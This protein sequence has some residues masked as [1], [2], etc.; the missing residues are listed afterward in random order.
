MMATWNIH[1]KNSCEHPR[2]AVINMRQPT[3]QAGKLKLKETPTC[4]FHRTC[5]LLQVCFN[6]MVVACC[7]KMVNCWTFWCI[8][9]GDGLVYRKTLKL[10]KIT[11]KSKKTT[12]TSLL[13]P[14]FVRMCPIHPLRG[15]RRSSSDKWR[16][17]GRKPHP[18]PVMMGSVF[19]K[20]DETKFPRN[21]QEPLCVLFGLV[22][23][24]MKLQTATSKRPEK[25]KHVTWSWTKSG[26]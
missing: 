6:N 13:P 16:Q 1:G 14:P 15:F 9:W 11:Q 24:F 25:E 10:A 12:S 8:L 21:K 3:P 22:V 4:V 20:P 2:D 26:F 23:A 7:C 19:L 5:L 17:W 18:E